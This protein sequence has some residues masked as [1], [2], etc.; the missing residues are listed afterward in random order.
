MSPRRLSAGVPERVRVEMRR[1]ALQLGT[2]V[3]DAR[4]AR[5]WSV[6]DLADGAGVSADNVYRLESGHG[7]SME[8]CARIAVALGR[9]TE[10]SLVDPRRKGDAR[11]NLTAD[12]VHSAMGEYEARHLRSLGSSVGIDEPYQHFQ[13]A[14]RADLVAWRIEE[15]AFLHIENRTRFPDLQEM[16]GAYNAKRA[17]LADSLGKRLGVGR[18]NSET[19][20]IAAVWSAETLH[21]IRLRPDTF[22]SLCPDRA[23]A[24]GAWWRGS[25]PPTG[26][27]ST[28]ILIDPLSAGR[29][30]A[31][32][33]LEDADHVRPRHRGYAEVAR[34]L[35]NL[36]A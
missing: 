7:A 3:R 24:F 1:S 10:M 23:E 15:R 26:V 31:F 21:S 19:H 18:W 22:W 4:V 33:G 30:R 35:L 29:Q 9:R 13:F 25:I 12:P 6:R 34:R 5:R 28:L 2:Q 16:A 14:G 27:G 17:Y 20:V 11:A 8:T 36:A 32:V